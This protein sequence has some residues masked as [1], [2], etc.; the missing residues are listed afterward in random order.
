M[1]YYGRATE[2]RKA[3]ARE[4]LLTTRLSEETISRLVPI[5]PRALRLMIDVEEIKRPK[6]DIAALVLQVQAAAQTPEE[7]WDA[8]VGCLWGLVAL[9]T[10]AQ[11]GRAPEERSPILSADELRVLLRGTLALETAVAQARAALNR[12]GLGEGAAAAV[13]QE[14]GHDSDAGSLAEIRAEL[15]RRVAE[16]HHPGDDAGLAFRDAGAAPVGADP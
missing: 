12:R 14:D 6:S 5:A 13:L 10:R 7:R 2:T 3:R 15:A 16:A 4:M 8:L 1:G 9:E 11:T